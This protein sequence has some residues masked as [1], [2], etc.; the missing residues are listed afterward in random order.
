MSSLQRIIN[1]NKR[2]PV[3][4]LILFIRQLSVLVEGDL[5]ILQALGILEESGATKQIRGVSAILKRETEY[6]SLLSDAMKK[7]GAFP[8]I[9]TSMVQTAEESGSLKRILQNYGASLEKTNELQKKMQT[10]LV[11]P[12]I[13][14]AVSVIV[15]IFLM[16]YVIPSFVKL[17]AGQNVILP[18]PT[19]ILL[20]VSSWI[21]AY[22]ILLLVVLLVLTLVLFLYGR[23]ASGKMF[24]SR[25]KTKLPFYGMLERDIQSAQIAGLMALFYESNI[26]LLKFLQIIADGMTDPYQK[27]HLLSIHDAILNGSTAHHAFESSRYYSPIFVGMLRVGEE[28]GQLSSVMGSIASYLDLEAELKL[29]RGV[30]MM[31]PIL[32]LGMSFIIGFIVLSITMPMFDMIHLYDF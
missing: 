7:S 11:Y 18:L 23:S 19:R 4:S 1:K 31:E 14:S 9:F 25:M 26:N 5:P 21:S 2:L 6:G 22:G 17:F 30:T 3:S 29:R 32:I 27:S 12:V 28:S 10:A 20:A 13:L 8:E 24:F 16:T 15:L